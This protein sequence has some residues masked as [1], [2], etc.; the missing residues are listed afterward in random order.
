MSA[1][2][3]TKLLACL[4]PSSTRTRP[5]YVDSPPSLEIDFETMVDVVSGAT[6]TILAPAS[7][8]WPGPAYATDNTSP[9]AFGPT[10]HTDGYFMV[11]RELWT[12]KPSATK[13][14]V[15]STSM[16][17]VRTVSDPGSPTSTGRSSTDSGSSICDRPTRRSA[18][19]DD[20]SPRED[21]AAWLSPSLTCSI[22]RGS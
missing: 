17:Q 16:S 8:C 1:S 15:P 21:S 14:P 12:M 3:R 5:R 9:D 13:L 2:Q 22:R 11:S 20:P 6:C 10:S 18:F 19:H 4:A 7:W